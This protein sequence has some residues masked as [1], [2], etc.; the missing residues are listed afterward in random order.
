MLLK[1]YIQQ[2]AAEVR[3]TLKYYFEGGPLKPIMMILFL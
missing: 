2:K 1:L 3:V